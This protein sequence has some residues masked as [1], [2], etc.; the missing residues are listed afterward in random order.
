MFAFVSP[1]AHGAGC[2]RPSGVR[3]NFSFSPNE[4]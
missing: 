1:A 2:T 4:K 3:K